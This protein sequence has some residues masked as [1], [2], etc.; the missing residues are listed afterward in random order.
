MTNNL[1]GPSILPTNIAFKAIIIRLLRDD[2]NLS[3]EELIYRIKDRRGFP[4][5]MDDPF[6]SVRERSNTDHKKMRPRR[7]LF[8]ERFNLAMSKVQGMS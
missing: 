7:D 5:D 3:K 4:Q 1:G 2:P 6:W 8:K